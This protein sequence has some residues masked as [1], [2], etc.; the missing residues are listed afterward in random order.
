MIEMIIGLFDLPENL[1]SSVALEGKIARDQGIED[2]T[3]GPDICLLTVGAVKHFR[4]HVVR[5]ACHSLQVPV[6]LGRLRKTK[7]DQTHRIVVSYHNVI[8]LDVPM[9]NVLSMTVINR[10]K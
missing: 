2:D 3:Q 4:G 10:L 8:W 9:H 6:V 1:C 5:G 7:I